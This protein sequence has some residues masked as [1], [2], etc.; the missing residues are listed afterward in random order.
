MDPDHLFPLLESLSDE[1][2][3]ELLGWLDLAAEDAPAPE[4]RSLKAQMILA[5]AMDLPDQQVID[6]VQ[7]A[8]MA[9]R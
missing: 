1:E 4:E 7:R 6:M 8:R 3:D 9:K 2:L 5:R